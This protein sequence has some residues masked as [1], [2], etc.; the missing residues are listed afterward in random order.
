[1]C[2]FSVLVGVR[3]VFFLGGCVLGGLFFYF[4]FGLFFPV[5]CW[6]VVRVRLD[7]LVGGFGCF[8][9]FRSFF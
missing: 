4:S 1:V 3:V 5:W 8:V 6:L 9:V 7:L 2:V